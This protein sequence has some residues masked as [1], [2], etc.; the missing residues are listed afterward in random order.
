MHRG[1][2][3]RTPTRADDP[4]NTTFEAVEVVDEMEGALERNHP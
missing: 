3:P 2:P 4:A 1:T